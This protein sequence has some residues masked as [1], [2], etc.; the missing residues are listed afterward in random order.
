MHGLRHD[1]NGYSVIGTNS[2]TGIA[3]V[4]RYTVEF[5]PPAL[6]ASTNSGSTFTVAGLTTTAVL[7][8]Q[9]AGS[10]SGQYNIVPTCSTAAELRLKFQ[11]IAASTIGTAESTQRGTLLA[12]LF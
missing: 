10:L 8:F 12:F 4:Q 11:N 6:N 1:N 2:T 5:T 7:I 9:T 3:M